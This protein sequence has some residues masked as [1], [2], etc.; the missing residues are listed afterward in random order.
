M[1]TQIEINTEYQNAERFPA[2]ILLA[3]TSAISLAAVS[4]QLSQTAKNTADKWVL[5][6]TSIS[7]VL[8]VIAT[9]MYL[10]MRSIF[11]GELF[12]M[13]LVSGSNGVCVTN[14]D[15]WELLPHTTEMHLGGLPGAKVVHSW[16]CPAL[17]SHDLLPF[18]S[19]GLIAFNSRPSWYWPFG[20]LVYQ[21]S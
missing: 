17:L 20:Q 18:A 10:F 4:A 5:S 3:V 2:W 9:L 21:S 7:M 12:E 14:M 13:G 8:S 16:V 6:V 19:S 1:P 11:V 15:P